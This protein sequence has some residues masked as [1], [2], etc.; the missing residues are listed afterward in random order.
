MEP[1][2]ETVS[3][4]ES[5]EDADEQ[6]MTVPAEAR[7]VLVTADTSPLELFGGKVDVEWS[8]DQEGKT[9]H[10]AGQSIVLL[11]PTDHDRTVS[12]EIDVDGATHW[13]LAVEAYR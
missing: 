2:W 9:M 1:R 5:T 11:D 13:R 4:V 8:G 6:V 10:R 7:L 12:V 3:K